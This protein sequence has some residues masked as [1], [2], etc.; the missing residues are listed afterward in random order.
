MQ[1][2]GFNR[3]ALLEPVEIPAIVGA[4]SGLGLITNNWCIN[5]ALKE[6]AMWYF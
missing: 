3:M 1:I 4:G 6:T 5:K 2:N